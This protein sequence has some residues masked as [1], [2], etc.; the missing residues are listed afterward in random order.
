MTAPV[1]CRGLPLCGLPVAQANGSEAQHYVSVHEL[2]VQLWKNFDT[3]RVSV[4]KKIQ[5][6]SI[7]LVK[8]NRCQLDAL[9]QKGILKGF[10][11]TLITVKDAEKLCD[12]LQHSREKR[13]LEKHPLKEKEGVPKR[14]KRREDD[15][16]LKMNARICPKVLIADEEA[17]NRD[18][19]VD[20]CALIGVEATPTPSNY[21]SGGTPPSNCGSREGGPV[22]EKELVSQEGLSWKGTEQQLEHEIV[23][24]LN[25]FVVPIPSRD[26]V[27][28]DLCVGGSENMA[29]LRSYLSGGVSQTDAGSL[30]GSRHISRSTSA[31]T[32]LPR[33][34]PPKNPSL[35]NPLPLKR[36]CLHSAA[37][38]TPSLNNRIN[39]IRSP[40]ALFQS[41]S[42]EMQKHGST[43]QEVVLTPKRADR[44]LY[45]SDDEETDHAKQLHGSDDVILLRVE[46]TGTVADDDARSAS[47]YNIE[48]FLISRVALRP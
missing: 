40:P 24:D 33:G 8:C 37:N 32:A 13:G 3:P 11:A 27:A 1:T 23:K 16:L 42:P 44:F 12:G 36:P 34:R 30:Q 21:S 19:L 46:N 45:W 6:L 39:H 10:R 31:I 9:R 5:D 7:P 29:T 35:P 17:R 47:A 43:S 48:G 14:K 15:W 41:C 4:Q 38:S 20:E 22:A 25:S 26:L 18:P 28:L 2:A